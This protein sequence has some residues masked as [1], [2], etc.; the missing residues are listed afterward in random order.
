M[1]TVNTS[2]FILAKEN[3]DDFL[4]TEISPVNP[5]DVIK[6][7]F[8]NDLAHISI[9]SSIANFPDRWKWYKN[10][11]CSEY[12]KKVIMLVAD[13]IVG[14]EA[15]D[16][17]AFAMRRVIEYLV[18]LRDDSRLKEEKACS[19]YFA[20]YGSKDSLLRMAVLTK[21]AEDDAGCFVN[22]TRKAKIPAEC[23][24][25]FANKLSSINKELSRKEDFI[26]LPPEWQYELA[27]VS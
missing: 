2:R 19:D 4:F 8:F 16:A 21:L 7:W 10:T 23:Y 15:T 17:N 20:F 27:S 11:S 24:K 14:I 22:R 13:G 3:S 9:S 26:H 1:K 25:H 18:C 12:K 6:E 5:L